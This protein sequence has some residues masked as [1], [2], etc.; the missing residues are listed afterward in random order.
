MPDN[1]HHYS[2]GFSLYPNGVSRNA[3]VQYTNSPSYVDY[4]EGVYLG[5]KWFETADH[6]GYWD[7]SPYQGYDKVVQFP[8]GHGLTYTEFSWEVESVSPSNNSEITNNSEINIRV[9]VTNEGDVAG[10]D[11]IEAYVTAPYYDGGIEKPYVSLVGVTKTPEIKPHESLSVTLTI[12]AKDFESYD[13]YDKNTNGFK[14]YELEEGVYALKLMEDAHKVKK[15]T[16]GGE[17][18]V[19][20]IINYNVSSTIKVSHDEVTGSKVENRFT[21]ANAEGGISI[22]GSDSNANIA[23]ISRTNFPSLSNFKAPNDR[24]ITDNVKAYNKY[25]TEQANTWDNA[26]TDMFGNRVST[27]KPTFGSGAGS[28]KLFSNGSVTELG[29]RLGADY[30]SDEWNAVLDTIP[31]DQCVSLLNSGSFGSAA[32]DAVGKAK[33]D[34][35]DGPAQVRSFNGG[36]GKPGTGFPC[37]TV[38]AQTFSPDLA[39]KYGLNY[40]KEMNASGV[41]GAYAFGCNIHRSPFQ[42]R[43]YEYMSEDGMLT[44]ILLTKMVTGL[45]N[46]GKYCFLKHLAIAECEHER[47]AMY[48]WLTEQSLREIYLKPFKKVVQEGNCL[49]MM[50]SYNRIGGIWTGGSEHL[51]Q[52]I[53]RYEWGFKGGIVTDYADHRE[54]MN[55]AQAYR[56]GSNLGMNTSFNGVSG[57]SNPSS[58]SSARLLNR[59]REATKQ[60][61]YMEVAARYQNQQYNINGDPDNQIISYSSIASWVWWK[62]TVIAIQV[63]VLGGTLLAGYFIFRP[64][65]IKRN[66]EEI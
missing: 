53:L 8:F 16:M 64:K 54:Y 45:Q 43:N 14:G 58:S 32:V 20:A 23:F 48:T 9:K 24:A 27:T 2:N 33:S 7:Q 11:V 30:D 49:A 66:K 5:Y 61:L 42:G 17:N 15:V 10:K 12:Q 36:G 6:V 18:N 22:D 44:G 26:S 40:G 38:L 55:G 56:A 35:R 19:D 60:I 62:P 50:T 63:M 1:I 59:V 65:P 28:K 3:G 4:V 31:L 41:D 51:I 25:T 34:N 39:Y 29:L 21:G 13:C 37:E 52:G 57:F 47:E 46:T